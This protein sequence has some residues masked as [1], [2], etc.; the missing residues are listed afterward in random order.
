MRYRT[1]TVKLPEDTYGD[2]EAYAL[3]E[4]PDDCRKCHGQGEVEGHVCPNCQGACIKGN[5]SEA[6][7][8]LLHF[9]LGQGTSPEARAMAAAY[10]DIR[11][12]MVG[13]MTQMVHN[14]ES[15][16]RAEVIQAMRR[17]T[18]DSG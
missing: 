14:L 2:F 1:L 18:P 15:E 16:F 11:S 9:A 7:R 3:Q 8:Y 6:A 12:K 5:K 13:V 17:L 10:A 4:F